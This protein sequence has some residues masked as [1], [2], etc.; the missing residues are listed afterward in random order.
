MPKAK[1]SN[2]PSRLYAEPDTI[3]GK[4]YVSC[5]VRLENSEDTQE[6]ENLG[7]IVQCKFMNGLVTALIPVE[8][9][10]EVAKVANVRRINVSP[11]MKPLTD[12]A[13]QDTHVDD[14]L[15]FSDDARKEGLSKGYDGSGVLLAVIDDGIDFQHIAFKDKNGNSRIKRAYVYNG[16]REREYESVTSSAPTT[17]DSYSDHGTH[18]STTA[19]GSSVI[20]S[21]S[22]VTVTD[23]HAH[24][25]YGGMAPGADLYLAGVKDLAGSYLSN[26]MDKIISYADA[27][28]MPVVVSNSWGAIMGPRDGSGDFTDV[29]SKYFGNNHPNHVCLFA[30]SNDG[31]RSKDGEGGG[32]YLTGT[33][34]K[35]N[36]LASILRCDYYIDTDGGYYYDH[37]IADV[38]CRSTDVSSMECK[39]HVIDL[40]G[41]SVAVS[42]TVTPST[43]GVVVSGLSSYF[44]GALYAYKDYISADKTQLMLYAD[45][46]TSRKVSTV[47]KDGEEYYK[48]RYTLAVEFY[49]TEG[50]SIIDAWGGAYCYFT[51]YASISGYNWTKGSDDMSVSDEAT[52]PNVISIGAH[53]TKNIITDYTGANYDYSGNFTM[54]DIAYFSSYGTPEASLT[55]QLYPWV[56][57]PGAR[58]VAGVNHYS[59]TYTTGSYKFDRVNANTTYPYAAM[60]GT[61]MATPTAAGI[62]A[63]W[64]QAAKE[65]GRAMTS[66]DI[67]DVMRQTATNDYYTTNGPN[68]SHF[69]HGKINALA[70]IK[71]ILGVTNE[72]AI[73]VSL[74][75]VAFEGYATM[76]YTQTIHVVGVKLENELVLSLSDASNSYAIDVVNISATEAANGVDVTITWTPAT[77]GQTTATLTLS[78]TGAEDV[79]VSIHGTAEAAT[80]VIITD[81][82]ELQFNGNINQDYTKTV[83][84][85][86]RF[87]SQ[88]VVVSLSDPNGVFSVSPTVIPASAVNDGATLTVDFNA[89]TDDSFSGSITL[90][91]EGAEAVVISLTG[92]A[93]DGGTAADEYLNI[94][95][96]KTIDT[97]GWRTQLVDSLYHYTEYK[98]EKVAWLTLPV[99]GAFVGA[100]YLPNNAT[101]GAGSPQKWIQTNISSTYDN[102]YA[103]TSWNY[104]PTISSPYQG[105]STYFKTAKARVIGSNSSRAYSIR[106]VTFQV[107]NTTEVKLYG[108]SNTTESKYSPYLKV[109]ECEKGEDGT[110]TIGTNPVKEQSATTKGTVDFGA[111]GLD[112]NKIYK[113]EVG[114]CRGY[115]Y[116][117]A[118]KTPIKEKL[119]GDVNKNGVVDVG[120]VTALV[121]IILEGDFTPPY[122]YVNYDHE[123]ANVNGD[124]YINVSDITMLVDL[125][126]AN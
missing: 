10:N 42:I 81:V 75:E 15:T 114:V 12:A 26:A 22:K 110:L 100:K 16:S 37:V 117:V 17:D 99:Y 118:F 30:S 121:D 64:L 58:L 96:Y 57:A 20:I 48:S 97:Q 102:P 111:E 23:D 77:A 60:Q 28:N 40:E 108:T 113:V 76:T 41:D 7:V 71:Y 61:S 123:A 29:T 73:H 5:F 56:T 33:A 122:K 45:E 88:D 98:D 63:L 103:G 120:D 74:G 115:L 55:G 19:G 49:P 93:Q 25:T 95:K 6:V 107:T 105:S 36:P 68:A 82:S 91:S 52:D 39:V 54:G 43:N 11:L 124:E 86:G 47:I 51:D 85:S 80:P 65:T 126:L 18:T 1:A 44:S 109:Y 112:A 101:F 89:A 69:G 32:C 50:T 70:G 90:T 87:L 92:V 14:L 72:P 53:V 21:G 78:S 79:V 9:I 84:V 38:W 24:S 34:S 2:L 3:D 4:V 27:Q 46:L 59:S 106:T 66:E 125:I 116:E 8:R 119:I 31:G 94:A 83:N 67:K 62:V 13:R 104:T 35:D